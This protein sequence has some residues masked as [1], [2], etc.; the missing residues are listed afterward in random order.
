MKKKNSPTMIKALNAV[1]VLVLLVALTC[2]LIWGYTATVISMLL[3]SVCCLAAPVV[4]NSGGITELFT[5]I[6]EAFIEGCSVLIDAVVNA[7][8]SI[9]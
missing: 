1:A 2:I 7:F 8:S 6:F 9:F 4:I 5:G 3:G